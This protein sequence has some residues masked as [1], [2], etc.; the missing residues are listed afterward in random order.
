MLG[1][2]EGWP[3]QSKD[4]LPVT[5]NWGTYCWGQGLV[6]PALPRG[7][8]FRVSLTTF[9]PGESPD[10][11]EMGLIAVVCVRPWRCLHLDA[12]GWGGQRELARV[13]LSLPGAALRSVV[14]EPIGDSLLPVGCSPVC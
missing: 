14:L 11:L 5:G 8:H 2:Y 10:R 12:S 7:F 3:R 13:L 1:D 4:S 9:E 6:F